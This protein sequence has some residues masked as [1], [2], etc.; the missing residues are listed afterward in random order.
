MASVAGRRP[1]IL[2]KRFKTRI[3]EEHCVSYGYFGT[4]IR[5]QKT[6]CGADISRFYNLI[7]V[8]CPAGIFRDRHR[9]GRSIIDRHHAF[10]TIRAPRAGGPVFGF[11]RQRFDRVSLFETDQS[12][13]PFQPLQI[14]PRLFR[15]WFQPHGFLKVLLG[16]RA[17]TELGVNHAD[18]GLDFR[19]VAASG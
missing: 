1:G 14:L 19:D 8:W 13:T 5:E 4:Q 17:R 12:S 2:K 7:L 6:L 10:Q 18:G 15:I 16:L 11:S 3:L 9:I